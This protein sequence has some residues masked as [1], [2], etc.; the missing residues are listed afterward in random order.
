MQE[1]KPQPF[2]ILIDLDEMEFENGVW[3]IRLGKGNLDI[4]LTIKQKK[5]VED[6]P[7]KVTNWMFKFEE[8]DSND[9][10]THIECTSEPVT[11]PKPMKIKKSKIDLPRLSVFG[12]EDPDD[13][14]VAD[15]VPNSKNDRAINKVLK[16]PPKTNKIQDPE[17]NYRNMLYKEV[18]TR[19]FLRD[20]RGKLLGDSRKDGDFLIPDSVYEKDTMRRI[21]ETI[22]NIH[23]IR[24]GRLALD[25]IIV[26]N[27]DIVESSKSVRLC[28]KLISYLM[29]INTERLDYVVEKLAG[30]SIDNVG[31]HASYDSEKNRAVKILKIVNDLFRFR[32]ASRINIGRSARSFMSVDAIG[33]ELDIHLGTAQPTEERSF[34][35]LINCVSRFRPFLLEDVE[36]AIK[37]H[38]ES[39][40]NKE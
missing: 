16:Y 8:K 25:G 28:G 14:F 9:E 19:L 33:K 6:Q 2:H 15:R 24:G 39:R 11:P 32:A 29:E 18:R 35:V 22:H 12:C 37:L 21:A 31:L 38:R 26:K 20:E 17:V 3:S 40:K 34:D 1:F 23:E 10:E 7:P 30:L 13:G 36:T 27:D 5:R 4:Y